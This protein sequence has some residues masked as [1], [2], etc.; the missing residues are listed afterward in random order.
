MGDDTVNGLIES[1]VAL[2]NILGLS[3]FQLKKWLSNSD[4]V[5]DEIPLDDQL[6]ESIP[7]DT[8]EA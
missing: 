5:L 7:L 1:Q 4:E 6:I 2:T 8:I 3:G